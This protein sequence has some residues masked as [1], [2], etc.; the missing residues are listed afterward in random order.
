MHCDPAI[1]GDPGGTG[2]GGGGDV[3][4]PRI[5]MGGDRPPH[6]FLKAW[7][8]S[9]HIFTFKHNESNTKRL[10]QHK[11]TTKHTK[12]F[13]FAARFARAD[14]PNHYIGFLGIA[15]H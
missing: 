8:I 3:S 2:G 15:S 10:I 1:G 13:K 7:K 14:S 12:I 11:N 6:D 5:F 9:I 4:P